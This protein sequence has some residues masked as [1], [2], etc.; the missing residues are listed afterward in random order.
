MSRRGGS[1]RRVLELLAE[2]HS[3]L[4][5]SEHEYTD[6]LLSAPS[7][8]EGVSVDLASLRRRSPRRP[9]VPG[10]YVRDTHA[11][12]LPRWQRLRLPRRPPG[13]SV[14]AGAAR[15][16]TTALHSP[17]TSDIAAA[18][19]RGIYGP[20]RARWGNS[21]PRGDRR[22]RVLRPVPPSLSED[23]KPVEP[24]GGRTALS[25][26]ARKMTAA[27]WAIFRD[28]THGQNDDLQGR[29]RSMKGGERAKPMPLIP[30]VAAAACAQGA[31]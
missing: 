8:R 27:L 1:S 2:E 14:G 5:A 19:R 4:G 13:V 10:L 17:A 23:G 26:H 9:P 18:V 16:R 28:R 3:G 25:P 31:K 15:G 24:P 22:A 29:V 6:D 20:M 12:K 30:M 11:K 21:P 7:G